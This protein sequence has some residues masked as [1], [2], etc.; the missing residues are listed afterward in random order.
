MLV[1]LVVSTELLNYLMIMKV[2]KNTSLLIA[3]VFAILLYS[4]IIFNHKIR[5]FIQKGN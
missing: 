3:T 1:C 5:Q 4:Y 2:E